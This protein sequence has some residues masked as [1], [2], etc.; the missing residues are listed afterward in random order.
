M[1]NRG[2][3]CDWRGAGVC[4]HQQPIKELTYDRLQNYQGVQR[5][6]DSLLTSDRH[7]GEEWTGIK[8]ERVHGVH[9]LINGGKSYNWRVADAFIINSQSKS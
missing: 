9:L 8:G 3:N 5:N 1:I 2:K 4:H 6:A 7:T